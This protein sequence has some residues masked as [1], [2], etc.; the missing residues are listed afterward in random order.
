[1][2]IVKGKSLVMSKVI[3]LIGIDGSGKS[4]HAELL[5]NAL[6]KHRFKVKVIYAGNTGVRLG[7][8][9]SFIKVSSIA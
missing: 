5:C 7:R 1:V 9:F 8:R 6:K 4:T 3:A 2:T